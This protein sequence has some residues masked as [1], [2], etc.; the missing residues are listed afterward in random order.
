MQAGYSLHTSLLTLSSV[1]KEKS[2]DES[3]LSSVTEEYIRNAHDSAKKG[4]NQKDVVLKSDQSSST[5]NSE[6]EEMEQVDLPVSSIS[7]WSSASKYNCF[8]TG[9]KRGWLSCLVRTCSV[10]LNVTIRLDLSVKSI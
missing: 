7:D 5:S 4:T 1:T 10:P 2:F 3:T 9:R 6:D 8:Q